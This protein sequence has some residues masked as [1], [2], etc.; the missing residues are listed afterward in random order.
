[1]SRAEKLL[2]RMRNN[3]RGWRINQLETVALQHGLTIR[4]AKGSHMAFDHPTL[5]RPLII[6]V[7]KP[8]L[9]VYVRRL[10]SIID[11]LAKN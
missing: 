10:V 1:M 9:P 2:A 11:S 5:N 7:H 3:P 6:P 4:Q 8:I